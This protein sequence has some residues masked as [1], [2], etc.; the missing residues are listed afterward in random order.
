MAEEF[1]WSM[2]ADPS[3]FKINVLPAHAPLTAYRDRS[4]A[5]AGRSSYRKPLN[6]IW[7]FSYA[8]RPSEAVSGFENPDYSCDSWETIRVPSNIQFEGFDR[9]AYVNTQYPW[10]GRE[11]IDPGRVPERFN[12]TASYVTEFD[13][14]PF[15]NHDSV[16]LNFKGVESGFALWC[17][18]RF[19]GYSED[20]FTP[21]EF[22]LSPYLT[23]DGH[24]NK[25]AVR[26]FKWTSSSWLEDQDMYRLSGIFREVELFTKPAVHLEDLTIHAVPDETLKKA[27]FRAEL[28]L[29]NPAETE[30][31][32]LDAEGNEVVRGTVYG[33][34][35][36]FSAVVENPRLWSAE[37][38]YLYRLEITVRDERGE[39]A[40]FMTQPVG[41]RRFEMKDGLMRLNGQR[42]V[43][44]GVNRHE[45]SCD[46]GRFLD[47]E[48]T[49]SDIFLMKR[50][51]INA[52][53]TCHYP[54]DEPLYDFADRYGLYLI[55][56]NNMESHGMW[57]AIARGFR[58]AEEMVPGD[59]D[60][61]LPMLLD[62][63]NSTYQKDKNHP[64][65]LIWS[66]GNESLSGS[67]IHR[68]S[69]LFRQLDSDRLIHYEGLA[70]D[71]RFEDSSDMESQMYT[72]V[73]GIQH[74][75]KD[76][77]STKEN[78]GKPF[79]LCEYEHSMGNSTGN[80]FKYTDLSD[81]EP[82]YQGGFIWDFVDQSVR[83]KNRFGEE[84]Q[85]Y[86]GDNLERP[87]DYDFSGDGLIDGLRRP[88]AK[89][90]EVKWCYQP[91]RIQVTEQNVTVYN[92][93]LFTGAD[94]FEGLVLLYREG[95]F[96]LSEPLPLAVSPLEERTLPLPDGIQKALASQEEGE[97]A[98]DV[99][100]R[101]REKTEYAP[102]GYELAFGEAVIERKASSKVEAVDM[103]RDQNAA[104]REASSAAETGMCVCSGTG[105]Q[106]SHLMVI[107]GADNVGVRGRD[108]D[109]LFS[110]LKGGIVSY[111]FAGRE[112]IEWIPRPAFWRAPTSND[113]GNH[114]P[115]RTGMWKLA[116]A[117]QD[118][119]DV[120]LDLASEEKDSLKY[121]I[122]SE[123]EDAVSLTFR[124]YLPTI[125]ACHEDVVYTVRCDG[126]V[127]V[128]LLLD[129]AKGLPDLPEFGFEFRLNADFDRVEYYGLG[130]EENYCDRNRGSRLGIYTRKVS[131][132]M[133]HYLVPQETGNRTG[134]RWARVTD[135]RGRGLEFRG[136]HFD[137]P[138]DPY[139]SR[140]GTMEFSAIPYSAAQLE[141]ALHPYELPRSCF[142]V[143][144]LL[145]K[146]TGVGGDDSWGART[147]DEFLIHADH[148]L[149]F[150]FSF[151][152]I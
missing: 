145:L 7:K 144:H 62:R 25:L 27:S 105:L 139:A 80:L 92:R 1:N 74:F 101:T 81:T 103:R 148:P 63:V 44:R 50:N 36:S 51:N 30:L 77:P 134:V 9:P 31:A 61:Y 29:A 16:F 10:D 26:V 67:V 21:S 15:W 23:E 125:P 109:I 108:F 118:F 127:R 59:Q 45:F 149:R 142:T 135:Y 86:G 6:G 107:H 79:I 73:S 113:L 140:P 22:N 151:K 129:P 55:A 2:V 119:V 147:H 114:F 65:V 87:T 120:G 85:G 28:V 42:I 53:R 32:L 4:E 20:S 33:P 75:L 57:D 104:E 47:S 54:D 37:S 138:D 106:D 17:N 111:R 136:E 60:R 115:A 141:E 24:R 72:S 40:E 76:H 90:T 39:T 68:M 96:V 143:V 130:P 117:Y 88:Y 94:A 70:H 69:R 91:F 3:I 18:G 56:E 89:L 71:R 52:V 137:C 98:I 14:P 133:E 82:R 8:D 95:H 83:M 19:V 35:A 41:F 121:P 49:K 99:S 150:A 11:E 66:L 132:M 38:P 5:D 78:P 84:F 123:K 131:E 58:K 43:F 13:V 124:R 46:S 128:D 34:K 122:L 64:S 12:P 146:Q 97:Y 126:S 102:A 48:T 152:G 93:N 112:L 116:E 110:R 100:I